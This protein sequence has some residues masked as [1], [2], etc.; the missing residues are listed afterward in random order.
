MN[1][2]TGPDDA[3][4]L[5]VSDQIKALADSAPGYVESRHRYRLDQAVPGPSREPQR[6]TNA[7]G[8]TARESSG[9]EASEVAQND[10]GERDPQGPLFTNSD[11]VDTQIRPLDVKHISWSRKLHFNYTFRTSPFASGI[12]ADCRHVFLLRDSK[13]LLFRI[14][15]DQGPRPEI[16]HRLRPPEEREF[17]AAKMGSSI[18]AA[19]C[20]PKRSV[21][22]NGCYV[23]KMHEEDAHYES[24]HRVPS[25]NSNDEGNYLYTSIAIFEA[26]EYV[27]IALGMQSSTGSCSHVRVYKVDI[28]VWTSCEIGTSSEF[29]PAVE[30]RIGH[31][32]D[33]AKILNFSPDGQLLICS[34][35]AQ[36]RILV[37]RV[38]QQPDSR[39]ENICNTVRPFGA[40]RCPL[41]LAQS[42]S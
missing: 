30:G 5:L 7:P 23:K 37:W 19:I 12:S 40:V 21:K 9:Q 2:F 34:T 3:E 10:N 29:N 39:L 28:T 41:D 1:K 14:P 24:W 17:H 22:R 18:I 26:T 33:A 36:N 4:Y 42:S 25:E 11:W 32:S 27:L 16:C 20:T 8:N 6:L 13:L 38:I 31:S 35:T 15:M